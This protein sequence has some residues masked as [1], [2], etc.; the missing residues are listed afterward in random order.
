MNPERYEK[1]QK[2]GGFIAKTLKS[3]VQKKVAAQY[4]NMVLDG[5]IPVN[6]SVGDTTVV[7]REMVSSYIE[8]VLPD[9]VDYGNIHLFA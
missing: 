1:I 4:R 8:D 7:V 5:L 6:Q 3:H 9:D 2:E